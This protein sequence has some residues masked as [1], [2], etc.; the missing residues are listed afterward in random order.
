L[1]F[2]ALWL[3]PHLSFALQVTLT[4]DAFTNSA[5]PNATSGTNAQLFVS[6]T[7][8]SYLKFDL[9]TLPGGTQGIAIQR[10][11]LKLWVNQVT[12]AGAFD[13]YPVSG[14][15]TEEALTANG[16][17]PVGP[18]AVAGVSVA[19]TQTGMFVPVDITALVR[20]WRESPSSNQGIALLP[21]PG[22][23]SIRVDSKENT[24]TSHG[25][26]L[27]V[28]F[29]EPNDISARVFN[30]TNITITTSGATQVLTFDS[31]RWDTAS[32]FT[33]TVHPGRLFAPVKGKYLIFGH[34]QW[35]PNAT[36]ARS[37]EIAPNSGGIIAIQTSPGMAPGEHRMSVATHYELE[38]GDYVELQVVQF[39]GGPLDVMATTGRFGIE[40]GMVKLP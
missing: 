33:P 2:F 25:P 28:V 13:V 8:N 11:I 9:S 39:S 14:V 32:L 18:V 6:G 12:T 26:Q 24:G 22:G 1:V 31:I 37:I 27:D 29:N 15:W 21:A 34:V 23:I 35:A 19:T 7:R 40:F 30:S 38:A 3:L 20:G 17:P 16:A 5:Q 36:G 4:D 10:A